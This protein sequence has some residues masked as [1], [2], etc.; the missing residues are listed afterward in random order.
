MARK[1]RK[2]ART[3]PKVRERLSI[4]DLASALQGAQR[5][6]ASPEVPSACAKCGEAIRPSDRFCVSCGLRLTYPCPGC[7]SECRQAKAYCGQCGLKLIPEAISKAVAEATDSEAAKRE[8]EA[9][10][11]RTFRDVKAVSS[12]PI[13]KFEAC[14][15][16]TG[17]KRFLKIAADSRSRELLESEAKVLQGLTHPGIVKLIEVHRRFDEVWLEFER[18]GSR[19]LRFPLPIDSLCSIMLQ[20]AEAL[21][22][23]HQAGW[24][25]GD[26]KPGNL[27]IR[28]EG[29]GEG[30]GRV[31]VIDFEGAQ[32]PGPSRF[33]IHTPM[34]AAPEQIFGDRIDQRADVYAFGVTL[35]LFFVHDRLPSIFDPESAAERDMARILGASPRKE[36]VV[37]SDT[38][39]IENLRGDEDPDD[40]G[41]MYLGSENKVLGAKYSFEAELERL[42]GT[43]RRLDLTGDILALISE[44]TEVDPARRPPDGT[45][46]A[47]RMRGL[48]QKAQETVEVGP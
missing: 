1:T 13:Q 9:G 22:A 33:G 31:V 40:G 37:L 42:A 29:E 27:L 35:Y 21:A 2:N 12:G 32:R 46:L 19:G 26:I 4:E 5:L 38:T 6:L 39:V 11:L 43:N 25:H 17:E 36:R 16:D 15:R 48:L 8:K 3:R 41:E 14:R 44:A 20:V 23:V 30:E 34:F 10:F 24:F 18:I 47:Q 45:A 28:E 7:G